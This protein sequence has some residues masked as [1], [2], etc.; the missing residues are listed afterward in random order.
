MPLD[1]KF[2]YSKKQKLKSR[3]AI[4]QL[5]A[6]G[7][8][9]NAT[10]VKMLWHFSEGHKPNGS[11]L[12]ASVS[13]SKRFF[14]KAVQRNRIK[15]LM[16]EAWR[17]QKTSLEAAVGSSNLSIDV[18]LIYIGSEMPEYSTVFDSVGLLIQKLSNRVIE[19]P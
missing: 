1:K 10:P 14:K 8:V 3:K 5:F 4:G 11:S 19:R 7:K 17:L 16:R 15:R 2:G 12:K 18:M 6:N 13:A 9:I